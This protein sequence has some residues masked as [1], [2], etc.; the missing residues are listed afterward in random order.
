MDNVDA[1]LESIMQ[2]WGELATIPYSEV[3]HAAALCLQ[4]A[5]RLK[6]QEALPLNCRRYCAGET[7]VERLNNLLKEE[8]SS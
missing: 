4:G 3:V 5:P 1:L 8:T 6:V 2:Q 7:A